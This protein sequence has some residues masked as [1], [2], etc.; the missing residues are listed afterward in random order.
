MPA[1]A[2]HP[3]LRRSVEYCLQ[4][5]DGLQTPPFA[6]EFSYCLQLLDAVADPAADALLARLGGWLP[7]DGLLPVAGGAA[8]ETLRA[9]D[10]SPWPERPLRRLYRA[11]LIEAELDRLDRAQ[12]PDG[13]WSVDF[14][15]YSAAGA[16][17]WRGYATVRAVAVLQANARS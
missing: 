7:E 4:A 12:Q 8:G 16:L 13:G 11:E 2:G 17:E 10:V 6:I 14:D 1:V 9:L 15:S 3:W 5:I